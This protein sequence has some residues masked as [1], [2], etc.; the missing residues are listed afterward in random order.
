M[1]IDGGLVRACGAN[2][3]RS[4][5]DS[6]SVEFVEAPAQT[7]AHRDTTV[8]FMF[9]PFGRGTPRSVVDGL[10]SACQAAPRPLR[11]VYFNAVSDD[12]LADSGFLH[13]VDRWEPGADWRPTTGAYP[14]SF[15]EA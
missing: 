7:F 9:H 15:W 10:R 1:E 14:T 4:R 8:V 11:R 12:I 3:A 2:L 13:R 5:F 6:G